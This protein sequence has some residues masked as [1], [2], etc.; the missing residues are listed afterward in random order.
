MPY[1]RCRQINLYGLE[2]AGRNPAPAGLVTSVLLTARIL[3]PGAD[4]NM[5]GGFNAGEGN[6]ISANGGWGV[7]DTANGTWVIG[8]SVGWSDRDANGNRVGRPNGAG[9]GANPAL[10]DVFTP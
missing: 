8:N 7:D 9:A 5:I 10:N 3:E 2:T 1:S 4:G 6:I